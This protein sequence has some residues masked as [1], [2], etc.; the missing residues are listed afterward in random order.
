M[1][2]DICIVGSGPAGLA[3]AL[4]ARGSDSAVSVTVLDSNDFCGRKLLLTGGGRCNV[5]HSCSVPE[6]LAACAPFSRFLSYCIH[7]FSPADLVIFLFELG[8]ATRVEG[9]GMV[10]PVSGRA[11][12]INIAF[13][14]R[15]KS[16]GVNFVFGSKVDSVRKAGS[17]FFIYSGDNKISSRSL[18][19]ATGGK[20]WPQTGSDGSGYALS[21]ALGHA[22]LSPRP[23]LVGLV[24]FASW[25]GVI[26]GTSVSR[27]RLSSKVSGSKVVST[28]S[29][30]FTHDGIS[31]PVVFDFSRKLLSSAHP[32]PLDISLDFCPGT[33]ALVFE[34]EFLA[35][36]SR[37]PKRAIPSSLACFVPAGLARKLCELSGCEM[38]LG[39]QLARPLRKRL[40]SN[41]RHLPLRIK[42]SQP[43][44]E[45]TV[46]RGGVD[47]S[48]INSVTMG[49]KHCRGLFFAGE[50]IDVDGP[51]GGY[52]LQIAFS[53]GV[54]AGK[55]AVKV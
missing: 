11:R 24:T 43:L 12:D 51:C 9:S 34:R 7:A 8:I 26:S 13:F 31:G 46:T 45:A 5:T 41:F 39:S 27:V 47:T 55:S 2:T 15:A 23:S 22:I 16:L 32:F 36:V 14:E 30:L 33:D 4:A 52:N 6:F 17:G 28:G 25:P 3:A 18:I 37:Y 40:V 49:S 44:S 19:I 29:L 1:N 10:F 50:I 42:S 54:V 20:S 35:A 21:S 38:V 48:E 53:S